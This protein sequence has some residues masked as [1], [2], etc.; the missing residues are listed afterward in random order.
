MFNQQAVAV[1]FVLFPGSAMSLVMGI[2]FGLLLA[3]GASQTSKNPKNIWVVLGECPNNV[4][5]IS[6]VLAYLS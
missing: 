5:Q 4:K 1:N 3:F 6:V 2:L